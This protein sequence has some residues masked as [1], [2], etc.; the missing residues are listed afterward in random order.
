M[1]RERELRQWGG[2][3]K[4]EDG[5]TRLEAEERRLSRLQNVDGYRTSGFVLVQCAAGPGVMRSPVFFDDTNHR[6]SNSR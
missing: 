1:S 4:P 3:T 6:C 5:C 2:C